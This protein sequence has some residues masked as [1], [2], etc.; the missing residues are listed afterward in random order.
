MDAAA[1]E[2]VNRLRSRLE[3]LRHS[4][5][6]AQM[7]R[8]MRGKFDFLG[9]RRPELQVVS[10]PLTRE[11]RRANACADLVA[12]VKLLWRQPEREYQYMAIGLLAAKGP[13]L[14]KQTLHLVIE[15]AQVK[16]WWD[17][18]DP[19]SSAV[20]ALLVREH[21]QLIASIDKLNTAPNFW[22]RRCAILFQGRLKSATDAD[23]LFRYCRANAADPE[24]FIQKAIGWALREYA[25]TDPS[26]VH[27]FL[28]NVKLTPLAY[29][30][31]T[32]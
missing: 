9:L 29:R 10:R 24:F 28:Q 12:T 25:K 11:Y 4:G 27:T 17:T 32:R 3:S 14:P 6:A 19:L 26:A 7:K 16:S 15:L 5:N 20:M 13:Q 8:Y 18:I 23:R 2:F 31:A 22:L 21:P 30:E 1:V